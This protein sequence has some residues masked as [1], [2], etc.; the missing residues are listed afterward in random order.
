MSRRHH[1]TLTNFRFF[2]PNLDFLTILAQKPS[3]F[4]DIG[5]ETLQ[6]VNAINNSMCN[7]KRLAM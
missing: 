1:K 6:Y 2:E 7:N 4:L 3:I 5:G